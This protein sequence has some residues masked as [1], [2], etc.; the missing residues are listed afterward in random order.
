M[1]AVVMAGGEG[2]RLR[3][4]TANRPKP[5]APVCNRP[6]I[7][8]ILGLLKRHGITEIVVTVHYLADEIQGYLGDGSEFGVKI[9][10]S[11]EDTPLGTAGSVKKA[12]SLLRDDE[13]LI[14]SGD[15]LTDC[16]LTAAIAYH[17]E[18]GAVATL[19]LSRVENPLDYGLVA[20][21]EEGRVERFFEKP[22]WN[23]VFSDYANTGIYV[24]SPRVFE[25]MEP[26]KRYD[27][28][29]DI[30]P[31]LLRHG[32]PVFGYAS[33]GF[34]CDIG[35]LDQ[36]LDAQKQLLQSVIDLPI[37]IPSRSEHVWVG[38]ETVIH[39]SATLVP[40]VC[41][42]NH[43]RIK[44]GATV[45]PYSVVG[46]HTTVEEGATVDRSVVW[47]GVYIGA[48]ASL[49][50]AIVGSGAI[51][52][53]DASIR[54]NAV[55][56]DRCLVDVGATIRPGVKLWPDKVIERGATVTMSLIWGNKWR[57]S[58]FREL[59]AAGLSN[60]EITP[61]FAVKLGS[62][63]G[64]CLPA[65]SMVV[66][67]RDSTRSS[68]M[69]KRA[70]IA[71]LL[72]VGCDVL[73]L[74]GAPVTVARHFIKASGAQGAVHVRKLPGNARVTLI[75]LFDAHGAY[76]SR[77]EERKVESAFFR[78][79]FNRVDSEEIGVI[80]FAGRAIEE[81]Q[82]EFLKLIPSVAEGRRLRIVVDYGFSNMASYF[83]SMLSQLG[84]DS[85][86]V[87][88]FGNAK[89]APRTDEQIAEHLAKL[90]DMVRSLGYDLGVLF[91]DDGERLRLVDG[92][93]TPVEGY[94]LLGAMAGL[95]ATGGAK[96]MTLSVAAPDRISRWLE[97]KG[98]TVLRSK[99]DAKSLLDEALSNGSDFAGDGRGGFAFPAFHPGFDASFAFARFARLLS[100]PSLNLESLL[101][102]VPRF[103]MAREAHPCPWEMKGQVMRM[104]ND[105]LAD[106][107]TETVDGVKLYEGEDWT[108]TTP[109][110]VEPWIHVIAEAESVEAAH[111]RVRSMRER[112]AAF[113][114]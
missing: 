47:D 5:M 21:D 24:L 9:E 56:G 68:R 90:G 27:W 28:S 30:F 2:S 54:E 34:W 48:G 103:G 53:K 99:T 29:Q 73:D 81:Y 17:R 41:I 84:L 50:S 51:I 74:R 78:E 58:L 106:D 88:G 16:D 59:G 93:G 39:P 63:Y 61:D 113:A 18:K 4:I 94:S 67:S 7:E 65:R 26:R 80:E 104:L 92:G 62:A 86:S 100:Q 10:Y 114:G 77:A 42:G 96:K 89:S 57:G 35:S 43:A 66:T 8:H 91:I 20:V 101:S 70:V 82:F 64:S 40:P 108:L 32:Q 25:L 38:G 111:E 13:F 23:E 55:I 105:S 49:Q 76:I 97:G 87:N 75:E 110:L 46:D 69:I 44:S 6:I 1:K 15:A 52:K 72:S 71:S 98:V 102:E 109:D 14:I 19:V 107:R 36:Y 83:P 33:S 11:V 3:P 95:L 85:I 31:A 60:V 22:T 45:G 112:L 79:D 37:G 12:E